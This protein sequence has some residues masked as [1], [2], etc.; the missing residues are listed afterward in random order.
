LQLLRRIGIGLLNPLYLLE[1][2]D[3]VLGLV[4]LYGFEELLQT[5]RGDYDIFPAHFGVR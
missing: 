5:S 1:Q 2:E 3:S 4:D